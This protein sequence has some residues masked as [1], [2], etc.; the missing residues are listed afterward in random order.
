MLWKI[1]S[2]KAYQ[3]AEGLQ[4]V[5][6]IVDWTVCKG[7]IEMNGIVTL[8]LPD[9]QTFIPFQDLTQNIVLGWVWDKVKKQAAESALQNRIDAAANAP[10][11][12]DLPWV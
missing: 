2:L 12:K 4:S 6:H 1:N 10:I 3:Q 5:V 9:P 8:S 7:G 11:V